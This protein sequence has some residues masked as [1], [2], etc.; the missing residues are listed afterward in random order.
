MNVHKLY[1]KEKILQDVPFMFG[2]EIQNI[3]GNYLHSGRFLL[4]MFVY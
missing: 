3:S 4:E 2:S 1:L